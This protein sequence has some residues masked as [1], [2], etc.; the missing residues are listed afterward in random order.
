MYALS[1]KCALESCRRREKG[2]SR[3]YHAAAS[4]GSRFLN[5]RPVGTRK[6]VRLRLATSMGNLL[7]RHAG[8]T[9]GS[10]CMV[11]RTAAMVDRLSRCQSQQLSLDSGEKERGGPRQEAKRSTGR[12]RLRVLNCNPRVVAKTKPSERAH[13]SQRHFR[14]SKLAR[15]S[16]LGGR[17]SRVSELH[18]KPAF[19]SSLC[20]F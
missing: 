3:R 19:D 4:V 9:L 1:D 20:R 16:T 5:C 18:A 8:A 10:V 17:R 11:G 2:Q 13:R 12:E 6:C 7:L 15:N 14:R